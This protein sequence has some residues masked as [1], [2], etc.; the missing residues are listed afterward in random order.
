MPAQEPGDGLGQLIVGFTAGQ[1]ALRAHKEHTAQYVALGQNGGGA[2]HKILA[3]VVAYRHRLVAC[4]VLINLAALHNLL[5]LRGDPLVRQLPAGQ[6]RHGDAGIP[7]GDHGDLAGGL[8][9]SLAHLAGEVAQAAHQGILFEDDA[10]VLVGIDLQGVAL[11]DTHGSAD[12]LGNDHA[13]EIVLMCQVKH[14]IFGAL[15]RCFLLD[16][17]ATFMRVP[18][19]PLAHSK[20]GNPSHTPQRH[21]RYHRGR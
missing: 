18:R 13:P 15:H 12:F 3:P 7:V 10:A 20:Y 2:G 4:L 21:R 11:A 14:K 17:C 9:Q 19:L 1:F 8:V 6:A 16:F 5:Q